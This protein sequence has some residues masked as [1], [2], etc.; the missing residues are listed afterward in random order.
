MATEVAATQI[1]LTLHQ[2]VEPVG[3]DEDREDKYVR[4]HGAIMDSSGGLL[5]TYQHPEELGSFFNDMAREFRDR[6][7]A[8]I[9]ERWGYVNERRASARESSEQSQAE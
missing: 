8:Q 9:E 3:Y 6:N 4:V 5:F 2:T 1:T 7:K